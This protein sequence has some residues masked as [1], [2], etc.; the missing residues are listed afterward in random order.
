MLYLLTSNDD[1]HTAASQVMWVLEAHVPCTIFINY[2]SERHVV[3]GGAEEWLAAKGFERNPAMRSSSS[4]GVPNGPYA[5]PVFQKVC[6]P[7]RLELM[8]SATWEGTYFV[9]IQITHA[10]P[11][12]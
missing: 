7:G 11:A 6:Q 8:G 3:D 10:A 4:S 2:R 12:N 5:G 9:F 1:R